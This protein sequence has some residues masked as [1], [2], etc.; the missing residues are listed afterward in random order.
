MRFLVILILLIP[1]ISW[2]KVINTKPIN[3]WLYVKQQDDVTDEYSHFIKT[4]EDKII[5]DSELIFWGGMSKET[6]FLS[7]IQLDG[8][9]EGYVCDDKGKITTAIRIDK[10]EPFYDRFSVSRN[11]SVYKMLTAEDRELIEQMKKGNRLIVRISE[12]GDYC[13]GV[14]DYHFSLIGFAEAVKNIEKEYAYAYEEQLNTS[15]LNC[16]RVDSSMLSFIKPNS[17]KF[18][19][20]NNCTSVFNESLKVSLLSEDNVEVESF[21]MDSLEMS[22]GKVYKLQTEFNNEVSSNE[23]SKL[24]IEYKNLEIQSQSETII[25]K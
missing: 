19:L 3:D 2:G 10:N 12:K 7:S 18:E 13:D 15:I 22:K 25:K 8:L 14:N 5:F 24:L 6:L 21:S 20:I 17:L 23:V 11:E 16:I 4:T 9:S 1:H